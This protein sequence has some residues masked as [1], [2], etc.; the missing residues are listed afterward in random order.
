MS[1]FNSK[2]SIA[3]VSIVLAS[4]CLLGVG[5]SAWII[6][7]IDTK[8]TDEI[9][10]GVGGTD[11]QLVAISNVTL[12]DNSIFLDAEDGDSV[13]PIKHEAETSGKV[14]DLQ[15][16]FTFDIEQSQYSNFTGVHYRLVDKSTGN[17]LST[18]LNSNEDLLVFPGQ[19]TAYSETGVNYLPLVTT[20][21]INSDGEIQTGTVYYYATQSQ[22]IAVSDDQNA[23]IVV[24][25]SDVAAQGE[26]PAYFRYTVTMS[27]N[28]GSKFDGLN[29]SRYGE[30]VSTTLDSNFESAE[31]V[32][33][34]IETIKNAVNGQKFLIE[35]SH[36]PEKTATI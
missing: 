13:A 9:E 21:M 11:N 8:E 10:I 15:L 24:S 7:N 14:E 32:I 18:F 34:T 27:L 17:T 3:I 4:V 5:F 26:Q 28:W 36:F 6:Q 2:K 31:E 35:L 12:T 16:Q 19:F 25:A 23:N 1:K 22:T 33:A 29:P 30:G 20:S